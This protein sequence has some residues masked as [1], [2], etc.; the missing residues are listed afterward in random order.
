MKNTISQ[1]L[2]VSI[3][4]SSL[5]M[6]G[7][8]QA[9]ASDVGL[10]GQEVLQDSQNDSLRSIMANLSANLE[11]GQ[12]N[13]ESIA[14]ASQAIEANN[15]TTDQLINFAAEGMDKK[16][17][18]AFK[19]NIEQKLALVGKEDTKSLVTEVL[20]S[21]AQGSNFRGCQDVAFFGGLGAA[22]VAIIF[23]SNASAY[24]SDIEDADGAIN[25]MRLQRTDL[26][27]EIEILVSA[28]VARDHYLILNIQRDINYLNEQMAQK[29]RDKVKYDQDAKRATTIGLA[30]AGVTAAAV[31]ISLT[32]AC[33]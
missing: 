28:G 3:L 8:P 9:F 22:L 23:L 11:R 16:E 5:S 31:V 18:A 14:A 26:N 12:G 15:I 6:T 29:E 13:I 10:K 33:R 32:P 21:M 30:G 25:N 7:V 1:F 20:T 17:A 4:A 27:S 19:A 24:R 2:S